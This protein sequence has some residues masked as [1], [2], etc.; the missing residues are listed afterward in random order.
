[1]RD[2][3]WGHCKGKITHKSREI[4][5]THMIAV[6]KCAIMFKNVKVQIVERNS[7]PTEEAVRIFLEFKRVESAIKGTMIYVLINLFI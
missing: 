2:K 6:T 3:V 4:F 1:M 5:I 7:V